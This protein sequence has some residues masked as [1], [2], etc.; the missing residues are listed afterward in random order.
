MKT[1]ENDMGQVDVNGWPTCQGGD[2]TDK[3]KETILYVADKCPRTKDIYGPS[4][5]SVND[6][7]V[8]VQGW[9]S[10]TGGE[11]G[12]RL[13]ATYEFTEC[14]TD[15]ASGPTKIRFNQEFSTE[16]SAWNFNVLPTDHRLQIVKITI[17]YGK[18]PQT[19]QLAFD[20]TSHWWT[21]RVRTECKWNPNG[22]EIDQQKHQTWTWL[23]SV[24]PDK[25][26]DKDET[27]EHPVIFEVW[28][29]RGE[30]A[31]GTVLNLAHMK[32]LSTPRKYLHLDK[33][34]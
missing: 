4:C 31:R 19:Y 23:R 5:Y 16:W 25:L 33:S 20:N 13:H 24:G 30:S 27:F 3:G 14:P 34:L 10:I 18:T 15:F 26:W 11:F 32:E 8:S 22:V 28:N 2:Y 29:S 21:F 12:N 6:I 17:T 7:D 1:Y 9:K